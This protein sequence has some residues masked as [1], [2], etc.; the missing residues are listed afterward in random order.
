MRKPALA[1]LCGVLLLTGVRGRAQTPEAPFG[2][3]FGSTRAEVLTLI[4]TY[5][6]TQPGYFEARQVPAADPAFE[7]YGLVVSPTTG[8]CK[9]MAVGRDVA[10]ALDGSALKQA[11]ADTARAL[12][13]R[14]GLH[15]TFDYLRPGSLKRESDDWTEALMTRERVLAAT[16]TPTGAAGLAAVTLEAMASTPSVGYLEVHFESPTFASCRD[17]LAHARRAAIR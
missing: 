9:V 8:L 4:G 10:V 13:A 16:W 3:R 1:L 2:L 15:E 7:A 5:R 6:E 17:E 12:D 14:Y 11:F